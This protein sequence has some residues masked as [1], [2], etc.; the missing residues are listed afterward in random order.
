MIAVVQEVTDGEYGRVRGSKDDDREFGQQKQLQYDAFNFFD[1]GTR[2][3]SLPLLVA[4]SKP[5]RLC[6]VMLRMMSLMAT[7]HL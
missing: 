6:S 3:P 4:H 5:P 2:P 7:M 1:Y